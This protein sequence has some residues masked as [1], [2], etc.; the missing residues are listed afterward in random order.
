VKTRRLITSSVLALFVV[1]GAAAPRAQAQDL[2]DGDGKDVVVKA[3]TSCHDADNFTSKKH[4]K[5]E[6]K[7]VVDTMVAYGAEI[8]DA[9]VDVITTYLAKNFGK[10]EAPAAA[11]APS[12]G[13]GAAPGGL[14]DGPGKDVVMKLCT[15]C[16]DTDN[17]TMAKHTKAEWKDVVTTMVGYGA[18]VSDEQMEIVTTYLAKYYGKG[19]AAGNRS[20]SHQIV[21]AA[22]R[23]RP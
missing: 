20:A 8:S 10:G 5:A 12:A 13:G 4:T 15:T 18:E 11:P 16:H 22:L 7:E 21:I 17:I 14:A 6:W 1:V 2:P 9:N 19:N 23:P 3:C